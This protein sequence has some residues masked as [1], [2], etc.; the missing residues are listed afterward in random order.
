MS[1]L[2]I[3]FSGEIKKVEHRQ[4]GADSIIEF[5]ICRK[6]SGKKDDPATFTWLRVTL[7][8]PAEWQASKLV[9]GAFVSGVGD[10]QLR[11]YDGQKRQSAEVRC[12]SFDVEVGGPEKADGEK[13]PERPAAAAPAQ[14]APA[15][16][17]SGGGSSGDSEPPFMRSDLEWLA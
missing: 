6:N 11:S 16:P 15:A 7:W 14:R 17:A 3:I 13:W 10:F 12:S 2:K 5:Q 8:K 1:M 9:I 4:A